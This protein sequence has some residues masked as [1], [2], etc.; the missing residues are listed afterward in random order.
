MLEEPGTV[1]MQEI[2][3]WLLA[4]EIVIIHCSMTDWNKGFAN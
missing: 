4:V 2:V 1:A 3:I